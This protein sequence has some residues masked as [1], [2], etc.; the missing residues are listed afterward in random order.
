[1]GGVSNG[2]PFVDP[3]TYG[4]GDHIVDRALQLFLYP[5]E[6]LVTFGHR[7]SDKQGSEDL[8]RVGENQ[9]WNFLLVHL[10]S[11]FLCVC[12]CKEYTV[13]MSLSNMCKYK[14]HLKN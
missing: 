6:F 13:Y 14:N 11:V 10:L 7:G 9:I 2:V 8:R 3:P 5:K 1:M 12:R 4:C